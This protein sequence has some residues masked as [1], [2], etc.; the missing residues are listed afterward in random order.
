MGPVEAGTFLD[1]FT[2]VISKL[3]IGPSLVEE[4]KNSCKK[5]KQKDRI[6]HYRIF[7]KNIIG[8]FS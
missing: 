7:L 5:K 8:N 6:C 1:L 4:L 2:A 3:T